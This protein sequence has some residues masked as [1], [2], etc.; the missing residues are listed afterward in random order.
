MSIYVYAHFF[1]FN[2]TNSKKSCI[3]VNVIN[4]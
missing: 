1:V 4:T 3:M 2:F